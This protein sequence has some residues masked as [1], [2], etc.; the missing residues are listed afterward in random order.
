MLQRIRPLNEWMT[1]N[2]LALKSIR[3]KN[4]LI[5]RKPRTTINFDIYYDSCE[6]GYF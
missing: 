5:L 4:E 3:R 1:D 6:K 2:I